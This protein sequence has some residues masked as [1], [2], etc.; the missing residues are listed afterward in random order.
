MGKTQ[1]IKKADDVQRL[2]EYYLE[3]KTNKKLHNGN[4]GS[5][6]FFTH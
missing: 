5:Q 2:K 3:K 1:P 6:Y 4:V